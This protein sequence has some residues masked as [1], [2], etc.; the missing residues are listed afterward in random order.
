VNPKTKPFLRWAGGKRWLAEE[1]YYFFEDVEGAYF[2]PFLGSGSMFFAALPK[3]S[4]LSDIN[5]ELINLYQ[6]LRDNPSG[7]RQRLSEMKVSRECYY[8]VRSASSLNALDSAARMLFLNKTAFNGLYRVSRSGQFNVP[9]GDR[10]THSFL[11]GTGIE[12]AAKAL[13][14]A[15]L[16]HCDFEATIDIAQRG[17]MVYC[18]PAYTVKHDCNG[19]VRYNETVFTWADQVRLRNS[20]ISAAYRGAIVVVSN[21]AHSSICELYRPYRPIF[22]GRRSAIGCPNSRGQV[23]ESVFVLS[24]N[25]SARRLAKRL[26]R[27]LIV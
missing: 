27:R 21:A 7:L 10:K 3:R 1:L 22:V 25:P 12:D 9:F 24:E 18:D 11:L 4:R 2:E 17:D 15:V 8:Q 23:V 26:L 5:C 19:F 16:S 6:V 20:A 14:T 13:K